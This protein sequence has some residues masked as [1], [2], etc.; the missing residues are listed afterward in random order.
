MSWIALYGILTEETIAR[1]D[2]F[3]AVL[4][5]ELDDPLA[6][7]VLVCATEVYRKGRRE[8]VLRVSVRVGVESCD[9][10]AGLGGCAVDSQGDLPAVGDQDGSER[11]CGC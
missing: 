4:F 7:E 1:V 6:I 3:A 8:G 2:R 11:F 9:A 10:D 5:R